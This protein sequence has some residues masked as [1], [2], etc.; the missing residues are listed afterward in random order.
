MRAY[1]VDRVAQRLGVDRRT[2]HRRLVQEGE[3]FS[4]IVDAVRQELAAR[5]LNGSNKWRRLRRCSVSRA[6]RVLPL[7]PQRF[8]ARPPAHRARGARS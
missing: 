6:E 8:K 1:S 4:A 7:V 2:I 5:Y 3:T